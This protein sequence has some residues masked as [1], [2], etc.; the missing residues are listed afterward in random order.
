MSYSTL[1]VHLDLDQSNAKRL[2]VAGE[3]AEHFDARTVGVAASDI[4]PLYFLDSAAGQELLDRDRNALRA[5][6]ADGESEF[7]AAFRGRSDRVE[8]RCSLDRP[9]DFVAREARAADLIVAGS[10]RGR[11]DLLRR[12]DPGEL[13]LR[14][15]R[16][17]LVVPPE[18]E[19]LRL[20]TV[21]VAWKDTR[22]ARRAINDALPL[23]HKAK[24]VVVVE[25]LE[26]DADQAA[27]RARVADVSAWLIRRG[28]NAAT[29]ATKALIGVPDQL[30]IMAH[31]EGANIIVA[32]AYG[33]TRFQEWVFGGVTRTLLQQDECCVLLSH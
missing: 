8:W 28:I 27:A 18:F 13:A 19:W 3:L 30:A 1:M 23:L 4:Q 22:E 16:P 20:N 29:V 2:R 6:M 14:A 5:L 7:R 24:Q 31:D 15:G 26:P 17:V 12:V 25:L 33:H 11:S 9:T 32:G 21:L 10:L